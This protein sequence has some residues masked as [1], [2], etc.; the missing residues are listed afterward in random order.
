MSIPSDYEDRHPTEEERDAWRRNDLFIDPADIGSDIYPRMTN[1]SA[2]FM[3]TAIPKP[4]VR[5]PTEYVSLQMT[6][7]GLELSVAVSQWNLAW[8]AGQFRRRFFDEDELPKPLARLADLGDVNISI[9]PKTRSRY[10]EYEPLAHL[11]PRSTLERFGIPFLRAGT[12][13]F[14]TDHGEIDRYLPVDF[15]ERLSRAWAATVWP[16]L[17]SGSRIAAFS[18]DD[19]IRMLSHNLDFWIPA[20][21]EVIQGRLSDFPEVQNGINSGPV[22]LS[23]GSS[24]KGALV[25][26][27]KMG[28]DIW[29]GEEAAS[30]VVEDAIGAADATG[31]LRA[32]LDAVRSNRVEDDFS[33]QWSYA[34]E[35]FERKLYNKRSR[36]RIRFVEL[37]DTL[38][39]QS[40]G[41]D[42]LGN[43]ITNDFLAMLDLRNRQIVVLLNSGFTTT[44]EIAHAMGYANHS[45]VSKRLAHIRKIAKDY[46]GD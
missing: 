43:L 3:F 45:A 11:L 9:V 26:N 16:Y 42:L 35:D 39:V 37:T 24:L 2:A 13:P 15:E 10:F 44:T 8:E 38:P 14:I 23:D 29:T 5:T 25:S 40:A 4:I 17:N 31:R 12:W 20:V 33:A 7:G 34:R 46:F 22:I 21:T 41:S 18:Q 1:M 32:I 6:H 36:T 28:G 19:P 27:P 30:G